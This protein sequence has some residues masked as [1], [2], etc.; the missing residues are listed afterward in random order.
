MMRLETPSRGVSKDRPKLPIEAEEQKIREMI[1]RSDTCL[2]IGETGSGKSTKIPLY[3]LDE[4]ATGERV[5]ITQPRRV[6]ARSVARYVAEQRGSKIGG[7]I[8]FQVRFDDQTTEGTRANFMTVGILLRKLQND[9]L[10]KE[11]AM[12]MVDEAHERSID[13]D[14][15]LGL[16][17]RTQAAR[18]RAHMK[19][20][21]IL[22]TSATL[23]K[24]KFEHF[25]EGAPLL[26]VPGRLHPVEIV[27]E[28]EVKKDYWVT[29]A[30]RAERVIREEPSGHLLIFMPGK[31]EIDETMKALEGR[32][33]P[34]DVEILPLYGEMAP[35]DQDRIFQPSTKRKIVIS[36]NIAETSVTVPGLCAVI[37]SGYIKQMQFNDHSGIDSLVTVSHSKSGCDQR[38]GRAGRD[39]AGTC[40]RLY[41]KT[42]QDTV[43]FGLSYEERSNFQTPEIL[44]S[45][46]SHVVLMMKK[47]KIQDIASFD[48]IDAPKDGA[49]IKAIMTLKVLGALD[50]KEELTD[51]GRVMAELPLKPELA[52]MILAAQNHGCVNEVCTAGAFI[53]L[54][55]V[56]IRPKGK[57]DEADRAHKMFQDAKSDIASLLTIWKQY[58][59]VEP[60]HR[61]RWAND[62]YL[63]IKTLEE[64]RSIRFQLFDELK[65]HGISAAGE[66]AKIET[67]MTAMTAGL[68]ENL[69][70]KNGRF[71]YTRLHDG[72][73]DIFIH[74]GSNLFQLLPKFIAAAHVK[75]TGRKTYASMGMTISLPIILAAAPHLIEKKETTYAYDP[76][77]DTVFA[78][79]VLGLRFL[80]DNLG[81]V[82]ERAATSEAVPVFAAA[83]VNGYVDL[84]FVEHNRRMEVEL[85]KLYQRSRGTMGTLSLVQW[86]SEH[87][88]TACSKREAEI[89]QDQ[90][91]IRMEQLYPPEK[92]E[93]LEA[94]F[95]ES[96]TMK[97]TSDEEAYSIPL[98]YIYEPARSYYWNVTERFE[99]RARV[100]LDE[101]RRLDGPVSIGPEANKH[102]VTFSYT[103]EYRYEMDDT[104]P[105]ALYQSINRRVVVRKWNEWIKPTEEYLTLTS[106]ES[107]PT[108]EVV[109]QTHPP[110]RY[111]IDL[112]G[113]QLLAIPT[114]ALTWQYDDRAGTSVMRFRINYCQDEKA[115]EEEYANAKKHRTIEIQKKPSTQTE[116]AFLPP[117][118]RRRE[119]R[120]SSDVF[121][122]PQPFQSGGLTSSLAER[123]RRGKD[124]VDSVKNR[125]EDT[126]SL[127]SIN[128]QPKH[129]K[130]TMTTEIRMSLTRDAQIAQVVLEDLRAALPI[131]KSD[132]KANDLQKKQ[133]K[134]RESA[135]ERLKEVR[136]VETE[137]QTST[138]VE[139]AR[140]IVVEQTR[141]TAK[142][143]DDVSRFMGGR[144]DTQE[145]LRAMIGLIPEIEREWGGTLSAENLTKILPSLLTLAQQPKTIEE[146]RKEIGET[147]AEEF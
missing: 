69:L 138:D 105:K 31:R 87:L 53:E 124:P 25:F 4:L 145:R 51:I 79:S 15:T 34:A 131:I 143:V 134:W 32:F 36:T 102:R 103:D 98:E 7:E 18:E 70:M 112:D 40:Y 71:A 58:E 45:N 81:N 140:G 12:V 8:G 42:Q 84:P 65:R 120:D 107:L 57:E 39:R 11:F 122:S 113:N 100:T 1:R 5:A 48:L 26:E 111:G 14:I 83:L 24:E 59:S 30:E 93:E 6:A 44:R 28:P 21:K 117:P 37:D 22:V 33:S 54:P 130:E 61:F 106:E 76:L 125:P 89:M 129:Q 86:Y 137:L 10:L 132:E 74:P 17:K 110:I 52:R 126:D 49:I 46:L 35:E 60:Q 123:L 127:R 66:S 104:D 90:L 64:V 92:M 94:S 23:E 144:N 135:T 38:A 108:R 147:V 63:R 3:I 75:N 43:G 96:L 67:V 73:S 19:P 20:L 16:L 91:M 55:S 133:S 118:S 109:S 146:L 115:A 72:V 29:A 99:I 97:K 142:I 80:E 68:V 41:A 77:E 128:E 136:R 141:K 78:N 27:Y 13:I 50:E 2:F 88:G 116:S 121:Y 56:F 82:K 95:P 139:R 114:I 9:P 47:M 119:E 101:L 85:N 62:R